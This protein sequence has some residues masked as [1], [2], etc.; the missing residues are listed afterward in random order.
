MNSTS[1]SVSNHE[2][3]SKQEENLP[4]K[5]FQNFSAAIACVGL[6]AYYYY[7]GQETNLSVNNQIKLGQVLMGIAE[8]IGGGAGIYTTLGLIA[9]ICFV[10][11]I[12]QFRRG[13]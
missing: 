8:K 6:G 11:G 4:Q 12:I 2:Q 5:A 10:K 3:Q 7:N 13:M 9:F 1:Y